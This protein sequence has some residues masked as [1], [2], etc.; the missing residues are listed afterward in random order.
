MSFSQNLSSLVLNI[1]YIIAFF[2]IPIARKK[3]TFFP[4]F[5][6]GVSMGKKPAIGGHKILF[7]KHCLQKI[8]CKKRSEEVVKYIPTVDVK[9]FSATVV[10]LYNLY[11]FV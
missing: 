11:T 1:E 8:S 2:K 10:R 7:K 5:K 4:I 6:L 9:D 3:S